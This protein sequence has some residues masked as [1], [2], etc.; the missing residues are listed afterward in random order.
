M[1]FFIDCWARNFSLPESQYVSIPLSVF[2]T[3]FWSGKHMFHLFVGFWR[4]HASP[5]ESHIVL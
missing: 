3:Q 2:L 4:E 1:T 5:Y